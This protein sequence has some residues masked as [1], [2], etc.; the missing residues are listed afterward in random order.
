M[1]KS[2]LAVAI[3]ALPAAAFAQTNV[4]LYGIA[5]VGITSVSDGVN[6]ALRVDSGMMSTSRWGIRGSEDLGGGLAANFVLEG[7]LRVDTG[8]ADANVFQRR[9]NVG[10]SGGFGNVRIGRDYTPAF[11]MAGNW[12]ALGYGLYGNALNYT[13]IAG[14]T[15]VRFSNS[16]FYDTPNMGGFSAQLAYGFGEVLGDN[17]AGRGVSLAAGYNAG[18]LMVG[19]YFET[20]NSTAPVVTTK[21]VGIGGGYNF[22]AFGLKASW[23]KR[24]P[25]GAGNNLTYWSLGGNVN[26]GAGQVLAQYSRINHETAGRTNTFGVAYTYPMSKR[27]TLYATVGQASNSGYTAATNVANAA[28]DA[29]GNLRS[30]D[31]TV[32]PGA[33]N[34]NARGIGF[35]V[36]HSF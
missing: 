24:D 12:D 29:V 28:G 3:A 11:L 14:G 4:T 20:T 13:A 34:Q 26:V 30:S 2:L 18:P 8:A 32:N 1:K 5:D 19:A 15:S 22:G 17:S 7:G 31:N 21:K 35:G 25:D 6:S 36:R 10:F 27:T 9:A 33:L 23:Q 16:L